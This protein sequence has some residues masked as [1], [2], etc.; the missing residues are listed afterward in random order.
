MYTFVHY[1][2]L[3]PR[4]LQHTS[5]GLLHGD[6]VLVPFVS[7]IAEVVYL[8]LL[9]FVVVSSDDNTVKHCLL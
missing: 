4:S 3:L 2:C 6:K 8:F 9:F 7:C 5:T 1:C